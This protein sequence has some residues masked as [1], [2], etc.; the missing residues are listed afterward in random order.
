MTMRGVYLVTDRDLAGERSLA[1]IVEQAVLGGVRWVQLREKHV[2]TRAFVAL[3]EEVLPVC[4]A[5]GVPLLIN[6]RLD[7]AQAVDAD[8]VHLGQSDMDSVTARRILGPDK[9]IG[10]SV[11]SL[12]QVREAEALPVDY[13]GVSPV[14]TTP[15]KAELTQAFGLEGVRAVRALTAR[16]LVAIGGLNRETIPAVVEAGADRVAVVSAICAAADPRAAAAELVRL[17]G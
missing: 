9:T 4:R 15:T 17:A 5:H 2:S 16:P 11:E 8:G 14:Y 10:L 13:Y 6:D 3:A 12:D 1:W 7:V